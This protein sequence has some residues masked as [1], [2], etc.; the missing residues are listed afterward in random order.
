MKPTLLASGILISA[1]VSWNTHA[2]TVEQG[3]NEEQAELDIIMT[4]VDENDTPDAVFQRIELPPPAATATDID[5]PQVEVGDELEAINQAVDSL[6]N[7]A[8]DTVTET[9]NDAL[10][11][12]NIDDLPDDIKETISEDALDDL[13]NDR[14][15]DI[16]E[17]IDD[18]EDSLK[19]TESV[20]DAVNQLDDS[21]KGL[22]DATETNQMIELDK[23]IEDVG[24]IEGL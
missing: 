9:L 6:T 14:S 2:Q 23:A 18:L 4:I 19:A 15:T 12:G 17:A 13:V 8:A 22:E 3:D 10:S 24:G 16:D 5:L 1:M 11:S 7:D 20:D 21:L